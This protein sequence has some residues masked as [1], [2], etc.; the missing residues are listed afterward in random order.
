MWKQLDRSYLILS[1]LILS[2]P[3]FAGKPPCYFGSLSCANG[4]IVKKGDE[5]S[6]GVDKKVIGN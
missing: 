5:M 3:A 2:V 4:E 6:N 1:T